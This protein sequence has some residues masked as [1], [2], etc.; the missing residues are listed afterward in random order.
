MNVVCPPPELVGIVV[1]EE[2]GL[3]GRVPPFVIATE[4]CVDIE[5]GGVGTEGTEVD[6]L[7]ALEGIVVLGAESSGQLT[8]GGQDVMVTTLVVKTV[9]VEPETDVDGK[10]TTVGA[11]DG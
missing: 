10:G 8:S 2:L 11:C 4:F 7:P 9:V 5:L 3:P 6:G 1:I